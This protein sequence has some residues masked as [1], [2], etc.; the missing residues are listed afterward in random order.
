MID[1]FAA[2]IS[3]LVGL[4]FGMCSV[5]VVF[6]EWAYNRRMRSM[7][8]DWVVLLLYMFVCVCLVWTAIRVLQL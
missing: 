3:G 2:I 1:T 4:F 7:G 5:G 8:Q 6:E